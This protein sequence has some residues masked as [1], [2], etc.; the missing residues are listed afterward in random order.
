MCVLSLLILNYRI[1]Q[2]F[3]YFKIIDFFT[4]KLVFSFKTIVI[5][6]NIFHAYDDVVL[7]L[8]RNILNDIDDLSYARSYFTPLQKQYS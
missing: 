6:S 2:H 5:L 7:I 1:M 8:N 4:L 3:I